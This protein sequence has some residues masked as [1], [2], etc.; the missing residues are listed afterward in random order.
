MLRGN[1]RAPGPSTHWT[2]QGQGWPGSVTSLGTCPVPRQAGLRPGLSR[3]RVAEG[4]C[5]GTQAPLGS[6]L[7]AMSLEMPCSAPEGAWPQQLVFITSPV[8]WKSTRRRSNT[9][10]WGTRGTKSLIS[11]P[12][13]SGLVGSVEV[14]AQQTGASSTAHRLSPARNVAAWWP[15][16]T[17]PGIGVCPVPR[18]SGRWGCGHFWGHRRPS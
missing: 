7:L 18:G 1:H 15:A 8:L 12:A 2:E 11:G 9:L 17:L 6:E 5:P 13:Q 3:G 4:L 14:S 16:P 10:S